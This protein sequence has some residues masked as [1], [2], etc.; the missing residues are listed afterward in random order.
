MKRTIN[1]ILSVWV[2]IAIGFGFGYLCNY[3]TGADA[4]L[5][6]QNPTNSAPLLIVRIMAIQQEVGCRMIDGKIGPESTEKINAQT[7]I[8]RS[9]LHNQY[10]EP[11]M[12]ASGA[13][14]GSECP[15]TYFKDE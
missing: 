13:P 8:D 15:D 1:N 12:T 10:A 14:L 4:L 3:G 6:N 11:Y 5:L 2:L 9:K 7:E